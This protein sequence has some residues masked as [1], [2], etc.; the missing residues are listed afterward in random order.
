ML[1]KGSTTRSTINFILVFF[2]V[3]FSIVI[4]IKGFTFINPDFEKGFLRGR[5]SYFFG[6]YAWGLYAHV[7]GAPP[8]MIIGAYLIIINRGKKKKQLHR[9]LGYIYTLLLIGV[10]A[11]GGL[12]M[13]VKTITGWPSGI[14]F[15]LLSIIW[16]SST[17]MAV[18]YARRLNF[19]MHIIYMQL[20]FIMSLAA[21]ILRLIL[22]LG[23]TLFPS[24]PAAVYNFI[25]WLCWTPQFFIWLVVN[26]RLLFSNARQTPILV[27][28]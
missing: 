27:A 2:V 9:I 11:P 10:A 19:R 6:W 4:A 16:V 23:H 15:I 25:A 18:G 14:S 22:P 26:R 12:I 28:E 13:S 24:N 1:L 8:V 5:E 20:S 7:I 17:I 3:A 21:L